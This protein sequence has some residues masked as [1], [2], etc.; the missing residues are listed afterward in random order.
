VLPII[1]LKVADVIV[2][3]S[4]CLPPY[5]HQKDPALASKIH[6][7]TLPED[8][9]PD[10]LH[11]TMS[12]NGNLT[13]KIPF[14]CLSCVGQRVPWDKIL[15]NTFIP[16]P[17]LSSLGGYFIISFLLMIT[18]G[19][20]DAL[21]FLSVASAGRMLSPPIISSLNVRSPTNYG[22]DLQGY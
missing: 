21:W 14:S 19:R 11:W 1:E 3:G 12:S 16:P 9:I 22:N 6:K 13:N 15:W 17:D 5:I 4:W 20:K 7:I 18:L 2:N 8:D 10:M